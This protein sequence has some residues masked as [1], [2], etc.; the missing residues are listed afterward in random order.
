MDRITPLPSVLPLKNMSKGINLLGEKKKKII[1]PG[2]RKLQILRL[3]ASGLLFIVAAC[4]IVLMILISFS[5]LPKLRQQEN[6]SRL[7]LSHYH[8]DMAKIQII[9]DRIKI[10]SDLL[11]KR[12]MADEKIDLIKSNTPNNVTIKSLT[13]DK[14]TISVVVTS[15]S[16]LPIDTFLNNLINRTGN[17]KD[18]SNVTLTSFIRQDVDNTYLV[19]LNISTYE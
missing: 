3:I 4:A 11:T 17:K 15:S 16:L 6:I 14:S 5:P 9:Q 8:D 7:N 18:F 2:L 19:G 10:I 13:I 1:T 12:S